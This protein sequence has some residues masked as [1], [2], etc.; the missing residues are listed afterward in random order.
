[1]SVFIILIHIDSYTSMPVVALLDPRPAVHIYLKNDG[2]ELKRPRPQRLTSKLGVIKF[3]KPIFKLMKRRIVRKMLYKD[4]IEYH[5]MQILGKYEYRIQS[6]KQMN[7]IQ[8]Q[9]DRMQIQY[10]NIL[11]CCQH[12]VQYDVIIHYCTNFEL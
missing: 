3:L 7:H 9:I 1:M 4:A 6:Q 12:Y 11:L 2:V 5:Y 10:C 8:K